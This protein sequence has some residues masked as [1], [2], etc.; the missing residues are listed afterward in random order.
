MQLDPNKIEILMATANLNQ[1]DLARKMK[2]S[3]Q[4]VSCLLIRIKGGSKLQNKTAYRIA[5]ALK[6]RVGDIAQ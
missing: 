2:T 5:K 3:A 4:W 1:G 6:C